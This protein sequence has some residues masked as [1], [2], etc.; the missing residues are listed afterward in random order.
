LRGI[1]LASIDVQVSLQFGAQD[2][3]VVLRAVDEAVVEDHGL[4]VGIQSP[5][6]TVAAA[7]RAKARHWS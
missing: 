5:P 1:Q 2:L 3:H 6:S 7:N 4:D